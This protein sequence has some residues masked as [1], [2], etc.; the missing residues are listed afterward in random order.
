[1]YLVR[2]VKYHLAAASLALSAGMARIHGRC[3]CSHRQNTC[4]LPEKCGRTA[5]Q[6]R[7]RDGLSSDRPAALQLLS[8]GMHSHPLQWK[9][10]CAVLSRQISICP[11]SGST[12]QFGNLRAS[13]QCTQ[14]YPP[15]K[16]ML[17][18]ATEAAF[19]LDQATLATVAPT[20]G[21]A[22][23]RLLA[24]VVSHTPAWIEPLSLQPYIGLCLFSHGGSA[25]LR[26]QQYSVII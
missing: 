15:G 22:R 1:M 23:T 9:L 7:F 12:G 8:L 3:F 20:A 14:S 4:W 10:W 21:P 25:W 5:L 6:G 13:M 2:P 18:H 19:A 16:S 11:C 17:A 26:E 24:I